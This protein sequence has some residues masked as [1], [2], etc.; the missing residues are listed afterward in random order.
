MSDSSEFASLRDKLRQ[1]GFVAEDICRVLGRFGIESSKLYTLG[2]GGSL[3]EGRFELLN[4]CFLNFFQSGSYVF[5]I[6][7]EGNPRKY[8]IVSN[9]PE[10]NKDESF[11]WKNLIGELERLEAGGLFDLEGECLQDN[12]VCNCYVGESVAAEVLEAIEACPPSPS[13]ALPVKPEVKVIRRKPKPVEAEPP[14]PAPSP[15]RTTVNWACEGKVFSVTIRRMEKGIFFTIDGINR[16]NGQPCRWWL[17]DEGEFFRVDLVYNP[18]GSLTAGLEDTLQAKSLLRALGLDNGNT[19]IDL[20]G[21]L[22]NDTFLKGHLKT[23]APAA[24]KV[25]TI[26]GTEIPDPSS[27]IR[28]GRNN[29]DFAGLSYIWTPQQLV[30]GKSSYSSGARTSFKTK[31]GEIYTKEEGTIVT[32]ITIENQSY[33]VEINPTTKIIRIRDSGFYPITTFSYGNNLGALKEVGHPAA[34]LSAAITEESDIHSEEAIFLANLRRSSEKQ[35]TDINGLYKEL[36]TLL[37]ENKN[38]LNA[39]KIESA[40]DYFRASTIEAAPVV[41]AP[42]KAPAPAPE[43][44][45]SSIKIGSRTFP[46]KYE[47]GETL[48]IEIEG[49][50]GSLS[51]GL[52]K[53]GTDGGIVINGI[54]RN[55]FPFFRCIRIG[56]GEVTPEEL[57]L[58]ADI[59]YRGFYEFLI[60]KNPVVKSLVE[61]NESRAQVSAIVPQ[62]RPTEPQEPEPEPKYDLKIGYGSAHDKMMMGADFSFLFEELEDSLI[63][64]KM[65]PRVDEIR[66][67][68]EILFNGVPINIRAIGKVQ[69]QSR[70]GHSGE[71]GDFLRVE[72]SVRGGKKNTQDI[73]DSIDLK[74]LLEF[75]EQSANITGATEELNRAQGVGA[76]FPQ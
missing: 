35:I 10:A 74:N 15:E 65:P 22:A 7:A 56:K 52:S 58:P 11:S 40:D 19:R 36:M 26:T 5:A 45:F 29:P 8:K 70:H 28:Y 20:D 1:M 21:K 3:R 30:I 60:N 63:I 49:L 61:R 67:K 55:D 34:Y 32:A 13:P 39:T 42:A 51:V 54:R 38:V 43:P 14:K 41:P 57:G 64:N 68:E 16:K 25:P 53:S 76:A 72:Y 17:G 71:D 50:G 27:Y 9:H 69:Q 6:F 47:M 2:K 23:C 12:R 31:K 24:K 33:Y 62:T 44:D 48:S 37:L 75:L 73:T 59:T 66:F 18:R 4:R 46:I